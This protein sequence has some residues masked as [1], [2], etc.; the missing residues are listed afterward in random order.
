MALGQKYDNN[1]KNFDPTLYSEYK[2]YNSEGIDPSALSFKFWNRMLCISISP[3]KDGTG[4]QITYD[5]ENSGKIY[6]T[7]IKAKMLYDEMEA[8]MKN[9]SEFKNRGVT[10]NSGGLISI[11]NGVE[12]GINNPVLTIQKFSESGELEA[13]YAYEFKSEHNYAVRNMDAKN[14]SNFEKVFYSN[15]ELELFLIILKDYVH[16]M[17]GA[18][19]YSVQ[20]YGKYDQSRMNTKLEAIA[21][22]LGVEF[23]SASNAKTG[24]KSSSMFDKAPGKTYSNASLEDLENYMD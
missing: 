11:S 16:A 5:H 3:K 17:N 24:Y 23:K 4:D 8:F 6:L 9:A 10:T 7:Y 2:L 21:E 20:E 14:P 1:K 12:F 15:I 22:K 13:S 18:I 19:A